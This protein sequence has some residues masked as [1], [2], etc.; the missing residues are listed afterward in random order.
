MQN[1][2]KLSYQEILKGI[3]LKRPSLSSQSE[4]KIQI[5]SN[6]TINQIKEPL[7][8]LLLSAGINASVTIGDYD[9]I[10]VDSKKCADYNVTIV[11]WELCNVIEGFHYKSLNYS[12]Q[13]TQSLLTKVRM[14][15]NLVANNLKKS[16]LVVW[17][18][19]SS[20]AFNSF[21]IKST[22]YDK[23][24]QA[25][26]EDLDKIHEPNFRFVNLDK[27]FINCNIKDVINLK[28][29]H[30]FKSLYTIHFFSTYS[31]YILPI[32]KAHTG[33]VKKV[34]ILDCDNT[35]WKGVIGEDGMDGIKMSPKD[36]KGQAYAEV[37]SIINYI[38]SQGILLCLCSKNNEADVKVV[39]DEHPDMQLNWDDIIVKKINWIDKVSNIRAI[40]KEL[41]LGLD[42]FI[43]I[44]DSDFEV[45]H[46]RE[47]LPEV[48]T[49]QVPTKKIF[50]YP[51]KVR[52]LLNEYFTL[53]VTQSDLQK[54]LQYKQQ[55]ERE[56]AKSDFGSM[57]EY[58]KSLE[59]KVT[60]YENPIS[61]IPRISQMTQKTNQ[62]NFTTK[63]YSEA[64]I[65]SFLKSKLHKLYTFKVEDKFGDYGITGLYILNKKEDLKTIEIDT[66]LMS[67]RVIGRKIEYI[68]FE[69]IVQELVKKHSDYALILNLLKTQKNVLVKDLPI[70]L[71]FKELSSDE[72]SAKF[73]LSLCNFQ[74]FD[75]NYI[76][77][78]IIALKEDDSIFS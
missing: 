27:I 75:I 61:Q 40:A 54:T 6:I 18:N 53:S 48:T 56:E 4:Y 72:K 69:N 76:N 42:S 16:S 58:L 15:I 37:Q 7:E 2:Q 44:D 28:F 24:C 13:E 30:L 68:V 59:L 63:R 77:S 9:S 3:Q 22:N 74:S 11:F 32:L 49:I 12:E 66:L 41:N 78:Q 29:Y 5:I 71:G 20:N 64:D 43:F 57:D 33:K 51:S 60:I 25:L 8:Y 55:L 50:E 14:E 70:K 67:C 73:Q 1:I 23:I 47:E 21:L 36:K 34:L 39:F 45:N 65:K 17:N 31:C 10:I 52:N 46:V 19:F 62:F 35:L 38:Q 26:N